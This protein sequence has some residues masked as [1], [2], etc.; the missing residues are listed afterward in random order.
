MYL[1]ETEGLA[2]EYDRRR[3]ERAQYYEENMAQYE[4]KDPEYR[5]RERKDRDVKRL[6]QADLSE[7]DRRR[8]ARERELAGLDG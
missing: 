6:P 1:P 2:E 8:Q 5:V 7:F 3:Y 4:R